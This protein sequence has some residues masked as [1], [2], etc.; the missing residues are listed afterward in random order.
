M[1]DTKVDKR[2][3]VVKIVFLLGGAAL[4]F[5]LF[6]F[7]GDIDYKDPLT[8]I[9]LLGFAIYLLIGEKIINFLFEQL[10]K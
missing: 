1:E 9:K 4:F 7:S 2:S 10:R 6:D 3:V 8:F 5:L